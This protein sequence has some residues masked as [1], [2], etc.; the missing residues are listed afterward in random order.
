MLC[1][2]REKRAFI[3]LQACMGLGSFQNE[4]RGKA[5][6]ES[7]L[8]CLLKEIVSIIDRERV[9]LITTTS[10]ENRAIVECCRKIGVH[11]FRG[12]SE[13]ILE[14]F[15]YAAKVFSMDLIIRL[16]WDCSLRIPE[17]LR[18]VI[19]VFIRE[20]DL[21]DCVFGALEGSS[22]EPEVEAFS[23]RTLEQ[24]YRNTH[25]L[26]E[27]RDATFYIRQHPEIFHT[28]HTAF[29]KQDLEGE[30]LRPSEAQNDK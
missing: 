6:G 16:M 8:L 14:S 10:P 9:V 3:V 26:K 1:K 7:L 22:K 2:I 17:V 4:R 29:S 18:E 28:H 15:Y 27:K 30:S 13:N 23:F 21:Y 5:Q 25:S 24:A 12:S 20:G 19:N 11:V